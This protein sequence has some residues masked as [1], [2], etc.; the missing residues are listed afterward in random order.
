MNQAIRQR[1]LSIG[2]LRAFAEWN[3][4]SAL[5]QACRELFGNTGGMAVPDSWSMQ[6]PVAY[7]LLWIV[8]VLSVAIVFYS[9]GERAADGKWS[10]KEVQQ[11]IAFERQQ[12]EF[13]YRISQADAETERAEAAYVAQRLISDSLAAHVKAR[14]TQG[15][16]VVRVTPDTAD[17]VEV[18]LDNPP[19][20]FPAHRQIAEVTAAQDSLIAVVEDAGYAHVI[21]Q[22]LESPDL[23][24]LGTE[25]G[26]FISVDGGAR[27]A[28]AI[29]TLCGAT[30][31]GGDTSKVTQ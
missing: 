14:V 31:D 1:P 15:R 23:L 5:T 6:N 30:N 11:K 17:M 16:R 10:E 4:V 3:P 20:C 24:F 28:G 9:C 21:R 7:T 12:A 25:T 22:D 29:A 8:G 13:A 27:W 2:P 18:C 19:G 26:L